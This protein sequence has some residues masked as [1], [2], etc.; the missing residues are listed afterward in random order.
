MS[1]LADFARYVRPNVP[2]CPEIQVLD[3]IL[4]AG[5][6]FCKRTKIYQEIVPVT[7]TINTD[8]YDL[9]M[10][11][12]TGS[13][14]DDVLAV[15]RGSDRGLTHSSQQDGLDSGLS[16]T[17]G[18]PSHYYLS[19]NSLTLMATPDAVETL[20]AVV[21]SRPSEAATT[22]PDVLYQRYR[23]EIAAGACAILMKMADKPWTNLDMAVFNQA[24]FKEA[25]DGENLRYA[26]GG[27]TKAMRSVINSF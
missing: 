16:S 14:P 27:G 3:A 2:M 12:A 6:D 24:L 22:L 19:G 21:K 17:T 25:I 11:M 1:A 5:I 18:T 26:K 10:L 9:A 23:L 7:T 20:S 8:S 15:L 4:H 13:E